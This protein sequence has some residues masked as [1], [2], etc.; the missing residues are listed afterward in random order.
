VQSYNNFL[1]QQKISPK[2][3]H[4][5][6]SFPKLFQHLLII[7]KLRFSQNKKVFQKEFSKHLH[8]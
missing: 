6:A 3:Y 5:K 8:I 7:S 1:T 4:Q 2:F